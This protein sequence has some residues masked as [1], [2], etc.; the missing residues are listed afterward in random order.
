[1]VDVECAKLKQTYSSHII[2][3]IITLRPSTGVC[4]IASS[5]EG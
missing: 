4:A 3:I 2:S 5:L 1:M